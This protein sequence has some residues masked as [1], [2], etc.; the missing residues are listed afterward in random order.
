MQ[1]AF[2]VGLKMCFPIFPIPTI[3]CSTRTQM[4]NTQ[5]T[6]QGAKAAPSETHYFAKQL[7][8]FH[9]HDLTFNL[10]VEKKKV[11]SLNSIEKNIFLNVTM[12][13]GFGDVLRERQKKALAKEAFSRLLANGN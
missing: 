4:S 9:V 8:L 2:D 1:L 5:Y 10:F 11:E 12:M 3:R 7:F 13:N 6:A